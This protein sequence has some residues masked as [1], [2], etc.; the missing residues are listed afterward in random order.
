MAT[1]PP[2]VLHQPA[3]IRPEGKHD[4][5][6]GHP[7]RAKLPVIPDL[8]FEYSYLRSIRP[9]VDIKRIGSSPEA[10]PT[11]V[12]RVDKALME[13]GYETLDAS[14]GFHGKEAEEGFGEGKV[15]VVKGPREVISVQWQKVLW[16][17]MRDQVISPLLQGALWA[18]ASYY[19]TPFS[20]QVGSR[21]GTFVREHVPTKEGLGVAWLRNWVQNL[22]IRANHNVQT[23]RTS[24]QL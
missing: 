12:E 17:T 22:G 19:L 10:E 20:A 9:Y 3:H 5:Q 8:R 23:P 18:L 24:R 15:T 14:L 11:T 2:F 7:H 1:A 16:V 21:V 6:H 4:A 13:E